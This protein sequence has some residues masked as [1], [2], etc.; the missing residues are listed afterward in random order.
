[1]TAV[2]WFVKDLRERGVEWIATLCGH[3]LDPLDYAAR[4]AGVRLVDV[5]NEQTAGYMAAIRGRLTGRPGVAAV[6]S[7]VAHANGMTGVVD[8]FLDQA[9]MLLISGS[10]AHATAGMG[11][12]QDLDQPALARPVTKYAGVIDRPERVLQVLNQAWTQAVSTPHGPVNLTFP[13]DIQEAPVEEADLAA[14]MTTP[15]AGNSFDPAEVEA[16]A[17]ALRGAERPLIIVGSGAYYAAEGRAIAEFSKAR[18]VPLA[19][20]IWDRGTIEESLET[21]VGILGAA[22]GGPRLLADAD[23][24]ILA[25][26]AAD[27]RVG[28]LQPGAIAEGARVVRLD[29]GWAELALDDRVSAGRFEGWLAEAGRR[30]DEFRA[31]VRRRGVEQAGGGLHAVHVVDAVDE[32]LTDETLFL[33]DGGSIGQWVHQLLTDR[34]PPN[35]LTCGRSGVVGWGLGGAMASRLTYPDRPVLLLTGD[36]SFTFTAAEIECAVRQ[37]LP[38]VVLVADDEALGITQSGHRDKYGEP[39]TSSLGPIDFVKLAEAFG[40]RGVKTETPDQ[41][42]A[43]LREGLDSGEVTVIHTPVVG[44]SPGGS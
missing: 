39:I 27:Y 23:L 10:H 18:G 22:T 28:F 24:I 21:F 35:W 6:S 5:R 38:F 44:G 12:F 17:E 25:G 26:A 1:M 42:A 43:A 20:P 30:R 8:A 29:R 3:G 16:A 34:Y 14:P 33:I 40:A 4:Q 36:G 7:G 11:H 2:D 19:I 31:T 32:V 9:P 13:M 37:K 41:L 15:I